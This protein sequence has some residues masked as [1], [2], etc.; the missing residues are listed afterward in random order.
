MTIDELL[1][2]APQLKKIIESSGGKMS[3][4]SYRD[5]GSVYEIVIKTQQ[6][7]TLAY[8]TKD[9][10]YL[11]FGSVY[12]KEGKNLTQMRIMELNRINFSNLNLADAL[13]Y[14]EG[15]GQKRIVVFLDPFCP[16]CKN[17]I[18]YLKTKK[19]Y[20][21]YMFLIPLSEKSKEPIQRIICSKGSPI[22]AYLN[23]SK[24]EAKECGTE[25]SKKAD[26]HIKLAQDLNV[27]GT[28]FVILQDGINFYGFNQALLE[29][30]FGSKK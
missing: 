6:G 25:V 13:T 9:F 27:R 16:H 23:F 11:L 29:S 2:Q 7:R 20:T 21:L 28:P 22:D 18:E 1:R 19:D 10:H 17:L 8:L 15:N 30:F 14:Q 4:E 12:D 5:L 3:A 24:L 26:L